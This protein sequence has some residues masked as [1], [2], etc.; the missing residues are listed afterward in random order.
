MSTW[1]V[2]EIIL[3]YL[4]L[5]PPNLDYLD[6]SPLGSHQQGQRLAGNELE[7]PEAPDAVEI[8]S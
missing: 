3:D 4:D 1:F 8:N 7:E 2:P 5:S 6:I